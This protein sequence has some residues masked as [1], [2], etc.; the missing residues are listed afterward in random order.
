MTLNVWAASSAA[1]LNVCEDAAL[2]GFAFA[3]GSP[4]SAGNLDGQAGWDVGIGFTSAESLRDRLLGHD[5]IKGRLIDVL[6]INAH[7]S[8]GRFDINSKSVV[9]PPAN[10]N[11]DSLLLSVEK[12]ANDAGLKQVMK[13]IGDRTTANGMIYLMGCNC[14]QAEAGSNLLIELSKLWPGRQV[15]GFKTI[16][17]SI[18]PARSAQGCQ[19][20]GM[21]DT[22]FPREAYDSDNLVKR[23]KEVVDNLR[24]PPADEQQ[25]VTWAWSRSVH[26]KIAKDGAITYGDEPNPAQDV[27]FMVGKWQWRLAQD[28]VVIFTF[29]ADRKVRW[30]RFKEDPDNAFALLKTREQDPNG[31]WWIDGTQVKFEFAGDPPGWKRLFTVTKRGQ[32]SR[33]DVTI[34]GVPHG[35]FVMSKQT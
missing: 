31:R 29:S 9:N 25:R 1:P 34:G 6:A 18:Q 14:G 20:P 30:E 11:I 21:R 3:G 27:Q 16:G 17:M 15:V 12:I 35:F 5:K 22:F 32:E 8:P 7:G 24:A 23:E 19:T 13:Q 10:Y 4:S 28:N 26:A 2:P 33:G